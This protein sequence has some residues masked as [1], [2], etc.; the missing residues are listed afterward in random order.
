MQKFLRVLIIISLFVICLLIGANLA[1]IS[2]TDN[3]A[4]P[5]SQIQTDETQTRIL[6]FV[7]DNFGKRKPELISIWSVI[8]YY[9]DSHGLM[10]IPLVFEADEHFNEFEKS[11][12][13]TAERTMHER[14]IKFF[15]TKFRTNWNSYIIMDQAA[16]SYFTSW[17]SMN[18]INDVSIDNETLGGNIEKICASLANHQ[19]AQ[20]DGMDWSLIFP[21]HMNS[22]LSIE[23]MKNLWEKL[24]ES[25]SILC[26]IIQ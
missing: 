1:N 22:D 13:V 9:Q 11:F 26:E 12:I 7:V 4:K 20:L 6:V 25:N 19:I 18:E 15:N 24:S 23:K 16:V 8:L 14:T 3:Q 5:V 2:L 17:I 21:N 10:F